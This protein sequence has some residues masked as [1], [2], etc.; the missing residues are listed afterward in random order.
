MTK[1]AFSDVFLRSVQPPAKGQTCLWDEK[2]PSFGLR[3][4]QGG[5]KTFV[6]NKGGTFITIGRFPLLSLSVARQEAKRQLADFTLG[7]FRPRGMSYQEAVQIYLDDKAKYRRKA[8]LEEYRRS[9][10][11]LP[12]KTLTEIDHT[13]IARVLKPYTKAY[14]YNHRL[15]ALKIFLNFCVKRRYIE[16]NPADGFSQHAVHSRSRTLT[17]NEIKLIYQTVTRETS[18]FNS[19]VALLLLCGQR[20]GEIAALHS[21]W[22][23]YEER[24]ITFPAN[25]TKNG[26][27]HVIPYG[28]LT[29]RFIPKTTG[30]L[31]LARTGEPY[32]KFAKGSAALWKA[33]G[34]TGATLHDLRRTY[35]SN[36]GRIGVA[37]HLAERLV[38]HISSRSQ[39]DTVYDRYTYMP[40]MRSAVDSYQKFLQSI[41]VG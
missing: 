30:H 5:S 37:P 31:F 8:T 29:A 34:V 7:R 15:V 26:R 18:A 10:T 1:A 36:L 22:I 14:E 40:E 21:S 35:R 3:V 24:T 17:D 4:S 28:E 25:I 23:N 19:I 41:G 2:L 39:M 16:H 9:L 6:L 32:K 11:K 13:A 27:Q 38:N 33:C 12:F 20:R